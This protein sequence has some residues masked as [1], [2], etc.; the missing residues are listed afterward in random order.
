MESYPLNYSLQAANKNTNF[1]FT[2]TGRLLFLL[3]MVS[4]VTAQKNSKQALPQVE[5]VTVQELVIGFWTVTSNYKSEYRASADPLFLI[6]NI[7]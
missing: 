1:I 7:I 5:K 3:S 4:D 6:K 2:K